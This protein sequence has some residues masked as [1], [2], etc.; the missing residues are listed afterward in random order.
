MI[1]LY[2]KVFASIQNRIFSGDWIAGSL[3]PTEVEL[4]QL[5]S[6]SRITVRRALDELA[7]LGLVERIQGKGT[8]VRKAPHRSG[9]MQ[10]GFLETMRDRGALVVTRL[11]EAEL[12]VANP[13]VAKTLRLSPESDGTVRAWHFRRLRSVNG[14]PIA[15]MNTIVSR[16]MGDSMR[17][18]DLER[19]SFYELYERISGS[20]VVKTES[21]V[22][23]I[24]PNAEICAL[25]GVPEG[26]AHLWYRSVGYL[27]DGEPVEVDYA[28]FNGS[29]Y[30]FVV[31]DFRLKSGNE[32]EPFP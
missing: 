14:T 22:S 2:Q 16:S 8:F 11:L 12:V 32:P 18:F 1:S 17:A 13:T 28:V 10:K 19:E 31:A 24:S 7:R 27:G 5:F 15:I 21:V 30:E 26:S 29:M 3:M 20:P 6:V 9:E 25:L 23:A 4:C